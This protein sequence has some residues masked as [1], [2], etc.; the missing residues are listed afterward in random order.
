LSRSYCYRP[1]VI[2]RNATVRFTH[3]RNKVS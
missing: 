1:N 2:E 3:D